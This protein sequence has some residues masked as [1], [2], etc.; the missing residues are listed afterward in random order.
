[1]KE[2][3]LRM[4]YILDEIYITSRLK[5]HTSTIV[6][7]LYLKFVIKSLSNLCFTTLSYVHRENLIP[8]KTERTY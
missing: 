6:Y 3:L 5:K 8:T 1:M 7:Y 4:N 2:F